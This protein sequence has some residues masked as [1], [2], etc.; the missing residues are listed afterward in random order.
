VEVRLTDPDSVAVLRMSR[1]TRKENSQSDSEN[2]DVTQWFAFASLRGVTVKEVMDFI[3]Y[4]LLVLM[5][6]T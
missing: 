6:Y 4:I 2:G 1:V 5:I 3:K